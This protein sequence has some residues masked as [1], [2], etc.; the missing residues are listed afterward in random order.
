MGFSRSPRSGLTNGMGQHAKSLLDVSGTCKWKFLDHRIITWLRRSGDYPYDR[1]D[2]RHRGR[3]RLAICANRRSSMGGHRRSLRPAPNLLFIFL[4][5][6]PQLEKLALGLYTFSCLGHLEAVPR[7]ATG[8]SA[9]RL[10]NHGRRLDGRH[11]RCTSVTGRVTLQSAMKLGLSWAVEKNGNPRIERV[12]P[13]AAI[14]GGEIT[15]H[16]SGFVSRTQARP[17]V[18]F[19][20][21][22]GSI[23]RVPDGATG[24]IVRVTSAEQESQPYPVAIGLQ[25]ADNLHPV[26][27]PAVDALGNI[28]VTFSG[29]R[30]QRVPVSL[31]KVTANYSIKPFVTSLINPTGLAV[32]KAGNLFVSCRHD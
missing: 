24:G 6:A 11:L 13:A 9:R 3:P 5:P 19:G 29:P 30:G 1:S 18:R 23:A 27:N 8:A 20:D 7:T 16:G 22:G 31:Y 26:G 12:A 25:I 21:A 2:G 28:Y 17:L 10:G 4:A 14:P 32:D 15:I